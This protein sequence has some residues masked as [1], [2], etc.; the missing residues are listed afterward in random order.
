M[1]IQQMIIPKNFTRTRPG[2][3]MDP[4]YITIH[5]TDNETA[6][7]NA[8]AHAKL[9]FNGNSRQA[10]WHYQVD[11]TAVIQSVP[12]NEA[13]WAAGDGGN[14]TG[15]RKSIHIEICVNKDGDYL[16]ACQNAAEL[17]RAKMAEH[18]IPIE[19]VVQHNKWSGKNCPRHMRAGDKGVTWASFIAMCKVQQVKEAPK[20][21]T[22][23]GWTKENSVWY[24]YI[25]G[26][27]YKGG[28]LTVDGKKYY[29]EPSAGKMMVG[30]T[31]IG[32]PGNERKYFF[33]PS[34]ELAI[35]DENG[36]IKG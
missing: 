4:Q 1:E 31:T 23:E 11:E 24:Y 33:L 21:P 5:E 29:L 3:A 25:N 12:D 9:Q 19:N 28:W 36:V 34:G 27:K 18:K 8:A 2:Y 6:G 20:A 30:L 15:N 26:E 7:A 16:K 14:G 32:G 35:T 22:K 10:S 17:V 13:A